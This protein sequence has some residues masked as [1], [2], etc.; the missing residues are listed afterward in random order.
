MTGMDDVVNGRHCKQTTSHALRGCHA[1]HRRAIPTE[2]HDNGA[3][4]D[5]KGPK[6]YR[7]HRH[8]GDD[9]DGTGDGGGDDDGGCKCEG[10]GVGIM[11][12]RPTNLGVAI[13]A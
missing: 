12:G 4:R 10:V 9:G 1:P 8:D 6:T 13:L 5:E 3:Q 11:G 7:E 2:D